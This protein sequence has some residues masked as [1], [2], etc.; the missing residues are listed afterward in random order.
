MPHRSPPYL[1]VTLAA[2]FWSGNFVLGR[3][4][5]GLI[6]PIALSFWRWALALLILLPFALPRLGRQAALIRRHWAILILLG[7]LGVT[8]FNT[9]VYL[10]LT[11][12]T[13]TNAVLLQSTTPVLIVGLSF[14]LL[15]ERVGVQQAA[16]ILLSLGGVAAIVLKGDLGMLSGLD[17]NQGDLWVLAAVVSW[18]LY[19]VCLRWRPPEL[20]PLAFLAATIAAGLIP[21]LPLYLWDL[22][23]VGGFALDRVTLSA[24]AYVAIFPSVLAYV[25]WNRAVAELG[26]TRTGQFMHLMPVFGTLLSMLLLGERLQGFH[27]AGIG[28][29]A[30]GIWLAAHGP[31]RPARDTAD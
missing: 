7:L 29:I 2:L 10:G 13:A 16:G 9:F 24:I 18:A 11:T 3:A 15:G 17:V 28:L 4:L 19:S 21:L 8:N 30:A 22:G 26:A 31:R 27:L 6:P 23:R 20:D 5:G 12:T 25:F 1:L 14:A